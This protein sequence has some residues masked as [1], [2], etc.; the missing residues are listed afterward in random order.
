MKENQRVRI[1]KML[2][3]DSLIDLMKT[4]SIYKISITNIC[5]N[6]N[7]NRSTFYNHYNTEFD[8]LKDIE[9][10]CLSTI[11]KYIAFEDRVFTL[12]KLLDYVVENIDVFKLFLDESPENTF[13][14]R[15]IE[16][17]L[18]RMAYDKKL[19]KTGTCN[20][21]YLYRFIIFGAISVV[22]IWI[23]KEERES[24]AEMNEILLQILSQ[25]LIDQNEYI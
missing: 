1:T 9:N 18:E 13:F 12:K 3:R 11:D 25:F 16:M 2:L 7:I 21:E 24:T 15:L 4:K 23:G 20:T 14:E 8:L 17:C 5:D 19:I 22:K 10:E 6:A